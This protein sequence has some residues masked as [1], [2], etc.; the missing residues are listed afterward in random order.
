MEYLVGTML[1]A[2]VALLMTVTGLN[3]ERALYPV[4]AIVIASYYALFA[5]IGGS[6]EALFPEII[7]IAVFVL[8]AIIGFRSNLWIVAGAI[9]AHGLFDG[10]HA[11]LIADPGV[12]QW[13]PGFCLSFDVLAGAWLA[14]G[15][16]T[17]RVAATASDFPQRIRPHVDAELLKA[18]ASMHRGEFAVAFRH[19]ERAHVLGQHSTREH[20]R[21]HWTMLLWAWRQWQWV[22]AFGQIVRIV[23][24]AFFTAI[25]LVP[26][27]NTGGANV[28]AFRP[29]PV[30]AELAQ[31]I[32]AAR[33]RLLP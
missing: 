28:S 26:E 32:T 21:V 14:Y 20:V 18:R 9:A 24:A 6:A 8:A 13:W 4:M 30:P 10:F 29:L 2:G 5:V 31:I 23:G 1:A 3:R 27:G 12:P 17:S 15:L 33:A 11:Q 16:L 22:E 7:G 19:L 25:G